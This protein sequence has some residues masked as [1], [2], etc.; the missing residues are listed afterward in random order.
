MCSPTKPSGNIGFWLICTT[1][2]H[3]SLSYSLLQTA[4]ELNLELD[5]KVAD[6]LEERIQLRDQ[7]KSLERSIERMKWPA[8]IRPA[9][10]P[11]PA[12]DPA[13]SRPAASAAKA[14]SQPSAPTVEAVQRLSGLED[15]MSDAPYDS[16]SVLS[17]ARAPHANT[18]T[19]FN[20]FTG[21]PKRCKSTRRCGC[22]SRPGYAAVAD[23]NS[24]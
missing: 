2:S 4:E 8:S 12:A 5:A 17:F 18:E 1:S 6:L 11:P 15:G 19:D 20:I 10:T 21:E 23:C 24:V 7:V 22:R 3:G 9:E 14:I 13:Y 16:D